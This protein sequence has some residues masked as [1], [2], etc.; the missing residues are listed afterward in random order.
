M[1]YIFDLGNVIID[2]DFN[3]VF[4]IWSDYSHVPLSTLQQRFTMNEVFCQHERGE[5]S[6]QQFAS[7]FAQSMGLSLNFTQFSHGWQSI[8]IAVR[9]PV[10]DI[11]QQL[12]QSGHRVVILSNTNQL[13]TDH[14]LPRYPQIQQAADALYLSQ[15][16]GLRK[17]DPAIYQKLLAD[18]R[19]S[20]RQAVFFDDNQHNIDAARQLGIASILVSDQHTIPGWFAGQC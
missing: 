5:I 12:R 1:L 11:M 10:I 4:T 15:R 2:I 18:E 19:S 9:Q 6:D 20:A 8:F 7:Q 3:R 14:W 16:M 17:P 13:H